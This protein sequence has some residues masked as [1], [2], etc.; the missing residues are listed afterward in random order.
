[1]LLLRNAGL[2]I[3]AVLLLKSPAFGQF[4]DFEEIFE[5]FLPE[6]AHAVE[7]GASQNPFGPPVITPAQAA[8]PTTSSLIERLD[9]ASRSV[10]E[11]KQALGDPAPPV[12]PPDATS[13]RIVP[14]DMHLDRNYRSNARYLALRVHVVNVGRQPVTIQRESFRLS[15]RG[16]E[17]SPGIPT[18]PGL[19]RVPMGTRSVEL[20]ELAK[21]GP[22]EIPAGGSVELE[23]GF[24]SIPGSSDVPDMTLRLPVEDRVAEID[25][26]AYALGLMRLEIERLGPR[27][28]LG[29]VTVGGEITPIGAGELARILEKLANDHATRLVLTWRKDAPAVQLDFSTWLVQ[30]ASQVGVIPANDGRHPVLSGAIQ[31]LHLAAFPD[32][33][34]IPNFGGPRLIHPT[35]AAAAT[36]AVADAFATM[37]LDELIREIEKGHPL[38]RPAAIAAGGRLPDERLPMLIDLT[39]DGDLAI[40]KAATTALAGFSAPAAIERL[41]ALAKDGPPEIR[42]A[43]AESLAASRF[44]AAHEA[45]RELLEESVNGAPV[46]PPEALVPVLSN[47]P[48][49]L[50]GDALYELAL[51]GTPEVRAEAL[52]ALDKLGHPSLQT[53]LEQALADQDPH[54][55]ARAFSLLS[56]RDDPKSIELAVEFTRRHLATQAPTQEMTL[57][58]MR[59]KDPQSVPLLIERLKDDGADRSS[60]IRLLAQIGGLEIRETLEEIY[61][62]LEPPVKTIALTTLA[63]LRSPKFYEYAAAAFDSNEPSLIN[64]AQQQLQNDSGAEAVA[65]LARTL[66]ESKNDLAVSYA[67][68]GL[69]NIATPAARR[70]LRRVYYTHGVRGDAARRAW[71]KIIGSSAG[72]PLL[73]AAE[74]ARVR[75][76]WKTAV[77]R[78]TEAIDLDA[79]L[80][81]AWAGRANANMQMANYDAARTD[82]EMTAELDPYNPAAI[83]CLGILRV[84]SGQLE[85]GLS[86]VRDRS[87]EFSES[88]LFAYNTACL[89][90]VASERLD[91]TDAPRAERLRVDAVKEL[92]RAVELGMTDEHDVDWMRK[93]PDLKSLHGRPDFEQAVTTA[94]QKVQTDPRRGVRPPRAQ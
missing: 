73:Q 50:W 71:F 75:E 91:K 76:E 82:Y 20:S 24:S 7:Q 67:A 85:E 46:I 41:V 59:T 68:Q 65:L 88:D 43:A 74:A 34:E 11:V 57:L 12:P 90:A 1:M 17:L 37:P 94:E 15:T 51:K 62:T 8:K 42:S 93:D 69:G 3:A 6:G 54:M 61:P 31:E 36:A 4:D 5:P 30:A 52:G 58:L 13:I 2:V 14:E 86:F 77:E 81:D 23:I 83:T 27:G 56:S 53:A 25:L 38:T 60:L 16:N 9:A 79:Q 87:V 22:V 63:Q 48:R 32:G 78:Y 89:Y 39:A 66:L 19:N 84:L 70:A 26:N 92:T 49:P 28:L 40:A 18:G 35:V 72:F 55:Q 45:L 29:L 10:R 44:G 64:I 47:H 33:T 21:K 80:I